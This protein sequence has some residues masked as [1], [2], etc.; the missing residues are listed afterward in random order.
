MSIFDLTIFKRNPG[1]GRLL[2]ASSITNLG[3]GVSALAFPWLAT[4]ITRDP[5]LIAMVGAAVRLPW[6]LFSIPAGV[7]TD[8]HDRKKLIVGSDTARFVLTLAV[9]ALILSVVEFPPARE[10]LYIA[11]L[12]GLGFALGLAEVLRDNAAQTLLPSI[13]QKDDLEAANGT[14]W[15]VE[16]IMGHFIGPPLAGVLIALALPLPYLLD[17]VSFAIAALLVA[18]I[19]IKPRAARPLRNPR[20]EMREAWAWM[21]AHPV[22]LRLAVMLGLLNG[23]SIMGMTLIIL[24][25]QEILQLGAFWHGVLMTSAAAGGVAGGVFGPRLIKRIGQESAVWLALALFP[26]P[27]LAIAVTSSVW[28]VAVALFVESVA[29]LVWNIVTVSYRQRVI[30]DELLGRVN[31]VYRFFGWGGIPIG[32]LLGGLLVSL[33][34]TGLGRELA[35][36]LPYLLAAAGMAG[37]ALYGWRK[38]RIS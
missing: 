14:L 37:L 18:G 23:L 22:I 3:D 36:R 27:M 10:G 13:V 33:F 32:A 9:V 17:A 24:V 2:A 11:G 1:Y 12:T 34:E 28:V 25:S 35:L 19:A 30:P 5:L 7:I 26:L 20:D 4:L 15:T 16:N 38:L 8:R 29:A 21:R 6:L 31:S